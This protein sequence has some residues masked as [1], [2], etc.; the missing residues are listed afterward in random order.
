LTNIEYEYQLI[1][2]TIVFTKILGRTRRRT[3][4]EMPQKTFS[5]LGKYT[6]ESEKY[7]SRLLVDKSF[8]LLSSLDAESIYFGVFEADGLT[9]IVY[10]EA[11]E[12]TIQRLK[13]YAAGAMR[14]YDREM[15]Q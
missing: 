10:F 12:T 14:A 8:L 3:I 2:D 1:D 5:L 4:I 11:T 13:R 7:L 15:K 6:P 9:C